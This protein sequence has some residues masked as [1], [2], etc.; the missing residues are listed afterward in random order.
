MSGGGG[1]IAGLHPLV[2]SNDY[3]KAR[4][5]NSPKYLILQD[6][7]LMIVPALSKDK[8]PRKAVKED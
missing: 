4:V 6:L 5:T 8:C 7:S 1:G 2:E 3:K